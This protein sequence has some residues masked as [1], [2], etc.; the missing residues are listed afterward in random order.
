MVFFL[1][2]STKTPLISIVF[3]KISPIVRVTSP[4]VIVEPTVTIF[5]SEEETVIESMSILK[6]S[7][8]L[9]NIV[10]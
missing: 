10:K 9:P 8:S 7:Y 2:S 4:T 6:I 1:S 5:L 3:S